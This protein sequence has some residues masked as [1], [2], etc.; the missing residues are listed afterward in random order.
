MIRVVM[1]AR[2]RTH[3]DGKRFLERETVL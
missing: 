2:M 1:D 3:E